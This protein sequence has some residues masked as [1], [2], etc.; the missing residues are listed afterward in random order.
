MKNLERTLQE[1]LKNEWLMLYPLKKAPGPERREQSSNDMPLPSFVTDILKQC[2]PHMVNEVS[3]KATTPSSIATT[4]DAVKVLQ[5]SLFKATKCRDGFLTSGGQF[6][7]YDLSNLSEQELRFILNYMR[8]PKAMSDTREMLERKVTLYIPS[9]EVVSVEVEEPPRKIGWTCERC[10]TR[11]SFAVHFFKVTSCFICNKVCCQRCMKES[12][13][14]IPSTGSFTLRT[15]CIDCFT[16]MVKQEAQNWL[17]HGRCLLESDKRKTHTAIAM[18]KISNEICPTDKSTIYQ[19]KA[20]FAKENYTRLIEFGKHVLQEAALA[21]G[22]RQLLVYYVAESLLQMAHAA[23]KRDWYEKTVECIER[24]DA[25]DDGKMCELKRIATKMK[26]NCLRDHH[27]SIQNK[28]ARMFSQLTE[29]IREGSFLKILV[30]QQNEDKEAMHLCAQMLL[31]ES[32]EKYNE[33]S[34]LLLRLSKAIAYKDVGDSNA[35]FNAVS[36]VFWSGYSQFQATE[37]NVPIVDYVIEFILKMLQEGASSPL[38]NISEI[39]AS[40]FLS[41]LQLTE[42][43]LVNLPDID[44]RKW[45]NLTV[46]GCDMK[47]F[48][49]YEAA[50][51]KLIQKQKWSSID[52]AFAY[53][54][55]LSACRHPSQLIMA[56][57]TSSQWFAREISCSYSNEPLTFA[58]KK[59]I[60]KLTNLAAA[61]AFEFSTYPY[62]QYYVA[63]LVIGLQFY[64]SWKT[65]YEGQET[66]KFIGVHMRW[67]VAAGRHCPLHK[68]AIVTTTEAVLMDV[69]TRKLH[70]QYLLKLQDFTPEDRRPMSEAI[71][72]YQIYENC[73]FQ[74]AEADVSIED[75]L[76]LTAMTELLAA[77]KWSW[78]DVQ[79]RVLS[80]MIAI[81]ENGWQIMNRKLLGSVSTSNIQRLVG[82]EINKKD[83]SIHILVERSS[84][85]NVFN[86]EPALL[87][88]GDIACGISLDQPGSFF[89]LEAI[90]PQQTPYHPFN[91]LIFAPNA[92]EGTDF[93]FTMLYTDY[94]LKQFSMGFEIQYFPP[95]QL[96]PMSEGLLKGLPEELKEALASIPSRGASPKRVHRLWIQADNEV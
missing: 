79:R 30:I 95:F 14:K 17:E 36:D 4:K 59:M 12:K 60:T 35:A 63:K 58:C 21:N 41:T 53:Y 2:D 25:T 37:R 80:S 26:P 71:L 13:C 1:F 84:R 27:L 34:K 69:I 61:L 56:L 54:D 22:N 75:G 83:F 77:K 9:V 43:D 46:D 38:E 32:S 94:L 89:S 73:W 62:M 81:D 64:S 78:D 74:R 49:K 11:L 18:Y 40:N 52:A 47:M 91:E 23:D 16:T 45:E 24:I 65:G 29:A 90:D 5:N 10:S 66:A 15:I 7:M 48:L 72:R 31:K 87:S 3:G 33:Y 51:K 96:R 93:L 28:A 92:L 19:V 70:C 88:M 82:L 8:V 68:M 6:P 39:K 67:L 50:V 42:A 55:L 85:L 57:I 20:L 44:Q 86:R 76:R